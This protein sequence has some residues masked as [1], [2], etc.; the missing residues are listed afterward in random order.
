MNRTSPYPLRVWRRVGHC[1]VAW[2]DRARARIALKDLTD[3]TLHDIGLW[4]GD[5]RM[6][7]GKLFWMP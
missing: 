6:S 4:R 7:P 3:S 5:K 2:H 1:F